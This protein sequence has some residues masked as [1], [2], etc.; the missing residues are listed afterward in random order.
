MGECLQFLI[1]VEVDISVFED[2]G[3]SGNESIIA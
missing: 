3:G 1:E 2:L